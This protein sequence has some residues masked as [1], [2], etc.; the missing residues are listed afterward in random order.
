MLTVLPDKLYII[1]ALKYT[2]SMPQGTAPALSC[3]T[4]AACL[5]AALLTPSAISFFTHFPPY[6]SVSRLRSTY[7][8][9][10]G[11]TQNTAAWVSLCAEQRQLICCQWQSSQQRN[12]PEGTRCGAHC[13]GSALLS[14]QPR[15]R[16]WNYGAPSCA[17][18]L[19]SALS[20]DISISHVKQ[21][22]QSRWFRY[23][24]GFAYSQSNTLSDSF[25]LNCSPA[26][27]LRAFYHQTAYIQCKQTMPEIFTP[28][29]LFC[30]HYR[31]N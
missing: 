8:A 13:Q 22:E 26:Q 16:P 2:K 9:A 24:H 27:L 20:V 4:P 7:I 5:R 11:T 15:G 21:S 1:N 28:R 29:L 17:G 23:P 12:R 25:Q 3:C 10:G 19:I 6:L 30:A 18:S 31:T 14:L